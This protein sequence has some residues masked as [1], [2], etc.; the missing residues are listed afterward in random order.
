MTRRLESAPDCSAQHEEVLAA[1]RTIGRPALGLAIQRDRSSQLPHL[2][3][4]VPALRARVRQGFSFSR[5]PDAQVLAIWD[6]LWRNSAYGDV[7]FAAI[8]TYLPVVRKPMTP[9]RV[10]QLWAVVKGWSARVDNWC[11]S[12]ALSGIYSRLLQA[13]LDTVQPQLLRWNAS[14]DLWLRRLSL[15][16]LI[17]Y[18][19]KNAVFLSPAQMMPLLAACVADTRPP[20]Q[21]ALGWVLRELSRA[22]GA[23]VDL[24]LQQHGKS[25]GAL[26]FARAIEKRSPGDR[27]LLQAWRKAGAG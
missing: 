24:F 15:T 26:A 3:I 22:H 19:G 23:A 14:N 10:A 9:E 16:S 25:M 6:T 8:E 4:T 5:L 17:H 18:S 21:L 13:D 12:D 20:V 1:L 2:G 7:L 27:A 11:H